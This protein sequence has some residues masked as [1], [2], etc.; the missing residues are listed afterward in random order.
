M[1]SLWQANLS[2]GVEAIDA[3]HRELLDRAG[4]LLAALRAGQ[5]REQVG[6]LLE[7]LRAYCREHFASEEALM[8]ERRY[9]RR[10]DHVGQ[11]AEFTAHL[12]RVEA[13]FRSQGPTTAVS[14]E[15]RHLLCERFV[16][17]ILE[18]DKGVASYVRQFVRG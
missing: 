3:Q 6:P 1:S 16:Q 2:V 12:D 5:T 10:D 18:A 17:H 11:H 15:L 9:P 14:A 4:T 13:S 7:F 8:L